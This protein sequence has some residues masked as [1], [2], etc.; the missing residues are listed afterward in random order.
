MNRGDCQACGKPLLDQS[1][2]VVM[3]RDDHRYHFECWRT[4]MDGR[5]ERRARAGVQI[6]RDRPQADRP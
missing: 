3:E 6:H 4:L 5:M 2:P 1:D